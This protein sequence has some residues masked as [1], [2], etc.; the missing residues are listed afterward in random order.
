MYLLK[1]RVVIAS[2][3]KYILIGKFMHEHRLTARV[4]LNTNT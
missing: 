2:F 4:I 3:V 1:S